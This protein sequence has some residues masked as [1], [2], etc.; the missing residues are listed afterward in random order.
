[1]IETNVLLYFIQ[2]L[3]ALYIYF[4][5][6]KTRKLFFKGEILIEAENF[7]LTFEVD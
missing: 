3:K 1:M 4:R 5:V 2:G 6:K 7:K